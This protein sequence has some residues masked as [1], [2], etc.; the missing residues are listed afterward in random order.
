MGNGVRRGRWCVSSRAFTIR[1]GKWD[2]KAKYMEVF[3]I[4]GNRRYAAVSGI[5]VGY[6]SNGADIGKGKSKTGRGSS[7]RR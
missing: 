2:E 5:P 3:D 4:V 7:D 6:C 1:G